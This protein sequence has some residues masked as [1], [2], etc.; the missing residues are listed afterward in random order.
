[1]RKLLLSLLFLAAAG[2]QAQTDVIDLWP[3]GVPNAKPSASRNTPAKIGRW[4]GGS[5]CAVGRRAIGARLA[6][7]PRHVVK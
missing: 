2:A 1:M 3:E 6:A 7:M 4:I 5:S